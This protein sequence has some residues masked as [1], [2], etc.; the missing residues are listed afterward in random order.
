MIESLTIAGIEVPIKYL[1]KEEISEKW[2]SLVV[3]EKTD[4]NLY[5]FVD[6]RHLI[7]YTTKDMHSHTTRKNIIHEA[8]HALTF[9]ENELINVMP[10]EQ[11]DIDEIVTVYVS[12]NAKEIA[13]IYAQVFLTENEIGS[14]MEDWAKAINKF[15]KDYNEAMKQKD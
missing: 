6:L 15:A 7:I 11:I 2:N 5:G 13:S 8:I 4:K 9:I 12:E 10:E 1:T 3:G 14:T